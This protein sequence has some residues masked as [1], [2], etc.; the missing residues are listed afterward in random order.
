M[1]PDSDNLPP[2]LAQRFLLWFLRE[3][4]QEEGLGKSLSH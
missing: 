2:Q 1:N 3:D 4:L